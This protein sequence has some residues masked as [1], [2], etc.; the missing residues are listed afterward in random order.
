MA[1]YRIH[2]M[3]RQL[4]QAE[5]RL[6]WYGGAS[7]AGV[8]EEDAQTPE[9]L[10]FVRLEGYR[11]SLTIQEIF[12]RVRQSASL[13]L[14]RP[15]AFLLLSDKNGL[16]VWYGLP[17]D[18]AEPLFLTAVLPDV[19][20]SAQ[21]LSPFAMARHGAYGGVLS[22]EFHAEPGGL[23]QLLTL[24]EGRDFWIALF[25]APVSA[26]Q[27]EECRRE[28]EA[29]LDRYQELERV[30]YSFG[31]GFG[32]RS[33]DRRFPGATLLID[34]LNRQK[35]LLE[36]AGAGCRASFL[37]AAPDRGEAAL[38]GSLLE[39]A[40]HAA[41]GGRTEAVALPFPPFDPGSGGFRLPRS[42]E[43]PFFDRLAPF[44]SSEE[45]SDSFCPPLHFHPGIAILEPEEAGALHPFDR[46]TGY[47]GNGPFIE[48]GKTSAGLSYRLSVNVLS[49]HVFV[50]GR[51]RSGKSTTVQ[52]LLLSL[53][54][55]F[56]VLET[57]KKEY[58]RLRGAIPSLRVYSAGGDARP[59][60]FNP[61]RPERG[62]RIGE[63][64]SG[65]M[66]AFTG[67]FD[68]EDPLTGAFT[69]LLERTYLDFG[70]TLE[71]PAPTRLPAGKRYPTVR[72]L[73]ARIGDY[74]KE[75]VLH[76][77]EVRAN[78]HG[79]LD[80]RITQRLC[81]GLCGQIFSGE[82]GIAEALLSG[83]AVVEL[84]DLQGEERSLVTSLLLLSLNEVIRRREETGG[85]RNLLVIEEAHTVFRAPSPGMSRSAA[86]V[87]EQFSDMLA[88]LSAYGT[89]LLIADQR[90]S[91]IH[92]SAI[93]NTSVRIVHNQDEQEDVDAVAGALHLQE[94]RRGLLAELRPGQAVVRVA[95][96]H[97]ISR[98][99]VTDRALKA[100][101]P[102]SEGCV[103][104]SA[105]DCCRRQTEALLS[106][107]S[108]AEC[109]FFCAGLFHPDPRRVEEAYRNLAQRFSLDGEA[110]FC[111]AGALV[112]RCGGHP[113]YEQRRAL[114]ALHML[115]GGKEL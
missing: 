53:S 44:F 49:R 66:T 114:A 8:T 16:E 46:Y 48:L 41:E 108:Q 50:C 34:Q 60:R 100:P 31:S 107:V 67:A 51:N 13:F 81:A 90:A 27:R 20:L 62:V 58:R 28:L 96:E 112:S 68:L 95:G 101:L 57:R 93:A 40:F 75:H 38:I 29:E 85:L 115:E 45:L 88:E 70:W 54:V 110:L 82:E 56:L 10:R 26:A 79:A 111:L 5:E 104:C 22:G 11:R 43:R 32:I 80:N 23:D 17:W 14:R 89:G 30:E 12:E 55:P 69:G 9:P 19:R 15:A 84:D 24:L 103:F 59:I 42:P 4:G 2:Q 39:G 7:C 37:Y 72:D 102:F 76:G 87:T 25:S 3:N 18:A 113:F 63:H 98:I 83:P 71:M 35:K 61:L 109:G 105:K 73:A 6:A 21:P 64:I 78:I 47:S 91:V 92:P 86:R 52:G 94:Y 36:Q 33:Q 97:E 65:L 1:N 106:S 99:Q 74:V 77:P